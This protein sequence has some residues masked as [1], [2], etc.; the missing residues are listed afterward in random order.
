M[1]RSLPLKI[2]A[3]TALAGALFVSDAAKVRAEYPE[4]PIKIIVPFRAGGATDTLAKLVAKGLSDTLGVSVVTQA[5]G[6]GGGAVGTAQASRARPDGY[7]LVVG[8]DGTLG[9]TTQASD[10]GYTHKDF[11]PLGKLAYLPMGVAVRNDS[12]VK[13]VKELAAYLKANPGTKY[14]TVGTGSSVHLTGATWAKKNGLDLVHIGNRGGQGA[15][16]KLLS[17]EVE[18]I[19]FGASR[20]PG[21]VKDGVGKGDYRPIAVTSADT[22]EYAP[23]IPTMK[24][25]G[26]DVVATSFWGLFA[27]K[28]TPQDV[29]DKLAA[30]I[31]TTVTSDEMKVTLQKF[32]FTPDYKDADGLLK[33]VQAAIVSY[34]EGLDA[35]GLLKRPIEP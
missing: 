3:V 34:R 25:Q 30:A 10:T 24:Q 26:Y 7:T 8:S 28:G 9:S 32:A 20:I 6:G 5:I 22:W 31:K 4:K 15:V 2:A 19:M 12:P 13:D 23:M 27:P 18:F 14:T 11:V 16:T 29:V 35:V 21:Q 33:D 1:L 17:K